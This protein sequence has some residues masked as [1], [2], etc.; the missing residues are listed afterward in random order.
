MRDLDT[1]LV[2]ET[3]HSLE[4]EGILAGSPTLFIRLFGCNMTCQGFGRQGI[5]RKISDIKVQDQDINEN[6]RPVEGCD[7][8]H[9]WH[10]SFKNMAKEMSTLE[11]ADLVNQQMKTFK[12]PGALNGTNVLSLTGGEP[13]LPKYQALI[14]K[15]LQ[16][17]ANK[18]IV[19]LIETNGSIPL[20]P[21]FISQMNDI[22]NMSDLSI[23]WSVSP[24]LSNSGESWQ[25]AIRPSVLL[26]QQSVLN[27]IQYLKF[28]S[29]GSDASFEEIAEVTK[30][31][32][33]YLEKHNASTIDFM[34]S[35][36]PEGATAEQLAIT[37]PTV[38]KQ[39]LARGYNFCPR[40]H[41]WLWGNTPR[42]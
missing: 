1:F 27:S 35:V 16:A 20:S 38:A 41:V 12:K 14:P 15:F 21:I 40:L 17:V 7:S 31:Y 36:M 9:A 39:C 26:D 10:P 19:L 33:E 4:G 8:L 28:V 37:A 32:R 5:P 34:V 30:V 6:F 13:T 3:F 23:M 22:V 29:D 11:L 25:K 18:G 42:T 2:T 24:K